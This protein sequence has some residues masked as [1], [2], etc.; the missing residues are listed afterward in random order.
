MSE[1][2]IFRKG[3]LIMGGIIAMSILLTTLAN[4]QP[5]IYQISWITTIEVPGSQTIDAYV[6][7]ATDVWVEIYYPNATLMGLDTRN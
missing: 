7:N 4:A 3:I 6:R 1:K 2:R 5:E